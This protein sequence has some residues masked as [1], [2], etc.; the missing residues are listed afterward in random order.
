MWV[1][2]PQTEDI[3][4]NFPVLVNDLYDGSLWP[5]ELASLPSSEDKRQVSMALER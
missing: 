3:D 1:F 4:W 5:N 2:V